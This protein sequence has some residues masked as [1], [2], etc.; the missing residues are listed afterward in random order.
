MQENLVQL[1]PRL[2]DDDALRIVA[3]K[4]GIFGE[5]EALPSERD[6]N[7]RI[8]A[9]DAEYV[10]K[11][12]NASEDRSALDLQNHAMHHVALKAADA[13]LDALCPQLIWSADGEEIA[14]ISVDGWGVAGDADAVESPEHFVRLLTYLPGKPLALA[15]P[16]VPQL[17]ASLGAFLGRIDRY[18]SDFSHSYAKTRLSLG[19]AECRA[20][21]RRVQRVA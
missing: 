14:T 20:G 1:A 16:Q 7:F 6:Q 8:V 18:L 10:L 11:I 12:A 13:R 19:S 17:H 5:I 2:T 9:D 21:R 3:E 15:R 4:Y